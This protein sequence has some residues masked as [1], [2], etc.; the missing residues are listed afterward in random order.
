V[1][2]WAEVCEAKADWGWLPNNA[3][4]RQMGYAV[5]SEPW[6]DESQGLNLAVAEGLNLNDSLAI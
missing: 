3:R 1:L 4:I 5:D 6:D 2:T